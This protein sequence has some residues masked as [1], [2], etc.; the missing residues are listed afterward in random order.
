MVD[1]DFVALC[2]FCD[3][4]GP[5]I[6]W[7]TQRLEEHEASTY[8]DHLRHQ[9][10]NRELLSSQ[11]FDSKAPKCP[12]KACS[13][14][15]KGKEDWLSSKTRVQG[16]DVYF[17]TQLPF[18]IS[19][20]QAKDLS[21]RCLSNDVSPV[22]DKP[23]FFSDGELTA[24]SLTFQIKDG[25]ARGYKRLYALTVVST[26]QRNIM[27]N[28]TILIELL[29]TIRRK[30]VNAADV[31]FLRQSVDNPK[32]STSGKM[33]G[34]HYSSSSTI[35]T[36]DCHRLSKG[37]CDVLEDD[38]I[39]EKLHTQFSYLLDI[40]LVKPTLSCDKSSLFHKDDIDQ[41]KQ[42]VDQ[43]GLQAFNKLLFFI[44]KS[45]G[46]KKRI[47]FDNENQIFLRWPELLVN[48]LLGQKFGQLSKNYCETSSILLTTKGLKER[49]S[50][51]KIDDSVIV[52]RLVSIFT[53]D[54]TAYDIVDLQLEILSNYIQNV[55]EVCT[56][57]KDFK[58]YPGLRK[59]DMEI[60]KAF[61]N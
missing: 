42:L 57:A 21:I 14:K 52:S 18:G 15:L 3:A 30:L 4:H 61:L 26:N 51:I 5:A 7:C 11:F 43:L 24:M 38:N 25:E 23:V 41:V 45:A 8:K 60:M 47:L 49:M 54:P 13:P 9:A 36:T 17:S 28:A 20:K 27:D 10:Q 44:L 22:K 29:G 55:L 19:Q 37:L 39:F 33:L 40:C 53:A 46:P 16:E 34:S 59:G 12:C 35:S 50:T 48:K 2:H 1:T 31:V 58:E 6:I 56:V 32:L